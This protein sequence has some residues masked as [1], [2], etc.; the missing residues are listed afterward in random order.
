LPPNQSLKLT[1]GAVC[2]NQSWKLKMKNK[3]GQELT[4]AHYDNDLSNRRSLA[5]IR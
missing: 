2:E 4:P 1:E 3:K 5:P